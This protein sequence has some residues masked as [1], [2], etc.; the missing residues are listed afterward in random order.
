MSHRP[1]GGLLSHGSFLWIFILRVLRSS[2]SKERFA[3]RVLLVGSSSINIGRSAGNC[4]G[5]QL[6]VKKSSIIFFLFFFFSYS[7][8]LLLLRLHLLHPLLS[9][10]S[11]CKIMAS[12]R[13]IQGTKDCDSFSWP[14]PGWGSGACTPAKGL[15]LGLTSIAPIQTILFRWHCCRNAGKDYCCIS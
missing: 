3:R 6:W 5:L 8:I 1:L 13:K 11:S 12:V 9:H 7:S 10:P 2:S 15:S 4:A 14:S